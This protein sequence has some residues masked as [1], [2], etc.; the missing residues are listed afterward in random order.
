MVIAS[1]GGS[2]HGSTNHIMQAKS[3]VVLMGGAINR[4]LI[5]AHF[6]ISAFLYHSDL[7]AHALNNPS[8]WYHTVL[9][10]ISTVGNLH[11]HG[12][13]ALVYEIKS[14]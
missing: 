14:Y 12:L 3:W 4:S 8:L 2:V 1:H 9:R 10:A 11:G 13:I 6:S 5:N 7:Y